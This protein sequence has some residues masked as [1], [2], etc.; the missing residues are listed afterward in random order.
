M[1]IAWVIVQL[2]YQKVLYPSKFMSQQLYLFPNSSVVE[3]DFTES[4]RI[5]TAL[6]ADC[7]ESD[8]LLQ[9]ARFAFQH[10]G[11]TDELIVRIVDVAR[12]IE[13]LCS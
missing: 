8:T 2:S 9:E 3:V 4:E 6:T 7:D 10:Q 5:E 13:S 11:S 1:Q 12:A